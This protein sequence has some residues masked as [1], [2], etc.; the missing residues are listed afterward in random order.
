[1]DKI[2]AESL[3]INRTFLVENVE[4]GEI[5]DELFAADVLS[6]DDLERINSET[7]SGDKVKMLLDKLSKRGQLAY[8]EF[9]KAL[10]KHQAFIVEKL[11]ETEKA[12]RDNGLDDVDGVKS[13]TD[14]EQQ[15]YGAD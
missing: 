13:N 9:K 10:Q 4:T 3:R 8:E 6:N 2:G 7:T 5:I 15:T 12:C 11:I 1:M 14:G